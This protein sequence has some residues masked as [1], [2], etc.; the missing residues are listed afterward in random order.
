MVH[1]KCDMERECK[2]PITH[3]DRKGYAYC[4]KHV[5]L[6]MAYMSCRKLHSEEIDLLQ[7]GKTITKW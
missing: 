7:Q 6:R 2:E 3:L 5:G 1:V 4:T